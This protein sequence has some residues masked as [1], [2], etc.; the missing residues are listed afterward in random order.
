[1][2]ISTRHEGRRR[3][4]RSR[5]LVPAIAAIG[6]ACGLAAA[7]AGAIELGD[8]QLQ[9][10]LGQ[11]LR[12]SIAYALGPNEQLFDFCIYLRPGQLGEGI[13]SVTRARVSLTEG[14]IVLTGNVAVKDPL[15]NVRLAVDCP[16]TPHFQREYTLM[17]N[18][19]DVATAAPRPA[20]VETSRVAPK[21]QRE[22]VVAA[23]VTEPPARAAAPRP[24]TDESPIP[25]GGK[26]RVQVGD[27]ASTI[28]SRITNRG[29]ALW[30]AV[31]AIVDANPDAFVGGDVDQL[32]AGSELTIPAFDAGYVADEIVEPAVAE[33]YEIPVEPIAEFEPV[34]EF[35]PAPVA[36]SVATPIE[37]PAEPVA[38]PRF[39][40]VEPV[41][42]SVQGPVEPVAEDSSPFVG[43]ETPAGETAG[44][45][46]TITA[47]DELRPGDVV[48]TPA[49]QTPAPVSTDIL[50]IEDA[51]IPQTTGAAASATS[52][53]WSW[54]IWLAGAGLAIILA[55]LAFRN[56]L[57]ERFGMV[58]AAAARKPA[59][60]EDDDPTLEAR[61]IEDLDFN[62]D[63]PTAARAMSLDADFE[64]GT[65]LDD[66]PEID[67]MQDFGFAAEAQTTSEVDL[68]L[69]EDLAREPES[70]PTD[71]IPPSHR[72][73][74]SSILDT[75]VPPG[76]LTGDYD[77]SMIV[78]ATRQPIADYDRTA[79]DLQAVRVDNAEYLVEDQTLNDEVELKVLEQDYEDELT[80][81]QALNL[82]IEK[83]ARELA[84][85]MD[86]SDIAEALGQPVVEANTEDAT[87]EMSLDDDADNATAIGEAGITE[88]V[89]M[90]PVSDPDLTAELTA[91]L[92][93]DIEAENDPTASDTGS[94]ETVELAAAGS[95][96]TV[97]MQVDSGK[98]DTK[99]NKRGKKRRK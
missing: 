21:T 45:G 53:A 15:L 66:N 1:V 36:D 30:P 19:R 74:E 85:R 91:K 27:T 46:L 97:D 56:N 83:A 52:G 59:E 92:P 94:R 50:P 58:G 72:I 86:E 39:E 18:T 42:E 47:T 2:K 6:G 98:V 3:P 80:A 77:M 9:S 7:P 73:D 90:P 29:I 79:H 48:V 99:K 70:Q 64:D 12:A 38:E 78:D 35:E 14:T 8:I 54:L 34:A 61:V 93:I 41:D 4:S 76:E 87:E 82:E 57:R 23:A 31:F 69:T 22:P 51:D 55:L 63:D 68:E 40:I 95:D 62:F 89:E 81:T 11:P 75:E 60:A 71:I 28:A 33:A 5:P 67:V 44:L 84:D 10:A 17:L 49:G 37:S 16:Y 65:G 26:Y 88:A 32:I 13:P 43:G 20:V 25:A 96:I 24:A